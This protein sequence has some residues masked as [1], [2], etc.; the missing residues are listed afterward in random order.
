MTPVRYSDWLQYVFDRPVTPNGW[1]FDDDDTQFAA[2]SVE[3]AEL[4]AHTLENVG[5]DLVQF[6]DEQLRYGL[7]YIFDNGC[8]DVVFALMSADAPQTLRLRAINAIRLL[9]SELFEQRCAPVLGHTSEAGANPL[10]YVCYMLWDFSPISY[11]ERSAEK[12]VM[13]PVIADVLAFGLTCKNKACVESGLHGLGHIAFY[14]REGVA[15]IIDSFLNDA[16]SRFPDLVEYAHR[17]K[18]GHVL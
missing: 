2:S 6:S 7:A 18:V 10:N 1:Y 17:A 4:V 14:F 8:S 3:L 12:H 16:E 11:W 15:R 5:R 13:Y 9:Y